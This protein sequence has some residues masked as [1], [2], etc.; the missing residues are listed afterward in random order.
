MDAPRLTPPA[1]L[2][3][4]H[5]RGGAG[6]VPELLVFGDYECPYTRM[7][8][9][10]VQRVEAGLGDRMRLVWRELPLTDLHPHAL[11]AAGFAEAAARQGRFWELHDLLIAHQD[12]LDV[13][14]LRAHAA[15]VGLEPRRLAADLDD[16][17]GLWRRIQDDVES[18][19]ASGAQGTPTL[20]VD[21]VL[22]V[23]GYDVDVLRT[24][25]TTPGPGANGGSA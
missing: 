2:A 18:A 9:R 19:R 20:F 11:A 14:D 8:Y 4:D 23:G 5:W 25:L 21:G 13:D 12:A 1:D 7:A 22:H 3:R 16:R 24:A 6:D 10:H 15:A 17:D